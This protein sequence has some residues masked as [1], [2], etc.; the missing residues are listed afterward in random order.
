MSAST[1]WAFV[2]VRVGLLAVLV[3]VCWWLATRAFAAYQRSI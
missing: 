1:D 3:V 2:G